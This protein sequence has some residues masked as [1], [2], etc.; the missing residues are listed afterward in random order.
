[1]GD[2]RSSPHGGIYGEG[3]SRVGDEGGGAG[4]VPDPSSIAGTVGLKM[5]GTTRLLLK[6]SDSDP[7]GSF[8]TGIPV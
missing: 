5:A 6:K 2:L 8:L 1:M 4:L 3:S 7:Q